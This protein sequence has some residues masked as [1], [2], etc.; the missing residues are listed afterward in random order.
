MHKNNDDIKKELN[1]SKNLYKEDFKDVIEN[2]KQKTENEYN[3]EREEYAKNK[4]IN[5]CSP[6]CWETMSDKKLKKINTLLNCFGGFCL[7]FGLLIYFGAGD[8]TSIFLIALSLYFLYFDPR[9]FSSK[10]K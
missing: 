8:K 2:Q 9:K 4:K 7:A 3:K 6:T 10:R 5:Y 1:E